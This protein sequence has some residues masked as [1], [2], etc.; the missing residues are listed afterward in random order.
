MV[1]KWVVVIAAAT[2]VMV[3]TVFG[4]LYCL[5]LSLHVYSQISGQLVVCVTRQ[6]VVWFGENRSK[7]GESSVFLHHHS[8]C[9]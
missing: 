7:I 3:A 9:C 5:L 4:I 8:H 1:A 2:V 6:L